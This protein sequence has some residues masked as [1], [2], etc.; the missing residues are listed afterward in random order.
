MATKVNLPDNGIDYDGYSVQ[1]NFVITHY[2]DRITKGYIDA[3]L[4]TIR[5]LRYC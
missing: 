4:S 2:D 5:F 1:G 3:V